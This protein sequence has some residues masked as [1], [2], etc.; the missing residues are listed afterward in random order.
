MA[1][2]HYATNAVATVNGDPVGSRPSSN[3]P[4]VL[5]FALCGW[6]PSASSDVP[7]IDPLD[8]FQFALCD[9]EPSANTTFH[10]FA[11]EGA[12]SIRPMR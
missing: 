6:E 5:K 3:L 1:P 9:G 12:V 4:G 11:P 2:F 10:A 8:W 7:G